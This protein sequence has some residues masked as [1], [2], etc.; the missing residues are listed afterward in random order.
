V[1]LQILLQFE[2][3]GVPLRPTGIRYRSFV[4]WTGLHPNMPATDRVEL[5]LVPPG[6][7]QALRLVLFEWRPQGGGYPGLPSD[8]EEARRRRDERLVVTEVATASLPPVLQV[9]AGAL[10][11]CCFDLRRAC[12]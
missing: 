3:G 12:M 10:T 4:P 7:E 1:P 9:P 8:R 5:V 6:A 11:A 2:P